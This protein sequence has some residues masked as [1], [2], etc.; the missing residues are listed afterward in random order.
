MFPRDAISGTNG[1]DKFL[2]D[3]ESL[4]KAIHANEGTKV[5]QAILKQK[6]EKNPVQSLGV[7]YDTTR[8]GCNGTVRRQ[9]SL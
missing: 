7:S 1:G 9:K 3:C 6:R 8:D 4:I 2:S 5:D